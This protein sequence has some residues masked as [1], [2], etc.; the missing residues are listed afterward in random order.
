MTH[1][2]RVP[3][4]GTREQNEARHHREAV[5]WLMKVMPRVIDELGIDVPQPPSGWDSPPMRKLEK[6]LMKRSVM[7]VRMKRADAEM[8]KILRRPRREN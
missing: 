5:A 3:R 4:V 7:Q 1:A 6:K 2:K 8:T